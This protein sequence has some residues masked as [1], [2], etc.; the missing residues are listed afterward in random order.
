MFDGL[1]MNSSHTQEL[2]KKNV[3]KDDKKIL[4]RRLL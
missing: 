2:G 1:I 3:I 4:L